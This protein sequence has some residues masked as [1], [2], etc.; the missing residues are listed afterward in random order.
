[1]D[2]DGLVGDRPR[3]PVQRP[4]TGDQ[5]ARLERLGEIV[6]GAAVQPLDPLLRPPERGQHQDGLLDTRLPQPRDRRHAVQSGQHPVHYDHINPRL[7]RD[8]DTGLGVADARHRYAVVLQTFGDCDGGQCIVL[9]QQHMHRR[10]P[11]PFVV[12]IARPSPRGR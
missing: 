5:L 9:D 7:P 8:P 3:P 12:L 6:V 11:A 10:P 1:M 4:D 2:Q